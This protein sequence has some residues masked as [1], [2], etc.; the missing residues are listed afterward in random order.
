MTIL[1][2]WIEEIAKTRKALRLPDLDGDTSRR[3]YAGST[4]PDKR[5]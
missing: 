4:T 1:D 3:G 2:A 5:A